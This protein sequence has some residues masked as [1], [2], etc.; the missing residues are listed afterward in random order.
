MSKNWLN[1]FRIWFIFVSQLLKVKYAIL[2]NSNWSSF[3]NQLKSTKAFSSA[4]SQTLTCLCLNCVLCTGIEQMLLDTPL[5]HLSRTPQSLRNALND[6]CC[7][8][9]WLDW[10]ELW[11]KLDWL[12]SYVGRSNSGQQPDSIKWVG[13]QWESSWANLGQMFTTDWE[14]SVSSWGQPRMLPFFQKQ[15]A[16]TAILTRV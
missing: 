11:C 1:P 12:G 3:N 7:L 16:F 14:Y 13:L 6:L 10:V 4:T 5:C 9:S 15:R 2:S 8:S